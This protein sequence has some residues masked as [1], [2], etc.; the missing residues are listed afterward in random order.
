LD[1]LFVT[2]SELSQLQHTRTNHL[3]LAL[4]KKKISI[5]DEVH[6]VVAHPF[7]HALSPPRLNAIKPA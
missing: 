2:F 4:D 1:S 7:C 5:D 6:R 3:L